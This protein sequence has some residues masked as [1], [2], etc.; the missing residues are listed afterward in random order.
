MTDPQASEAR[1]LHPAREHEHEPQRPQVVEVELTDN[2]YTLSV[3]DAQGNV[4]DAVSGLLPSGIPA[5]EFLRQQGVQVSEGS[6]EFAHLT[7]GDETVG[8]WRAQGTTTTGW[9]ATKERVGGRNAARAVPVA[10]EPP[11]GPSRGAEAD[12]GVRAG[13]SERTISVSEQSIDAAAA[14]SAD[15]LRSAAEHDG[16]IEQT[17]RAEVNFDH[18]MTTN[19]Y[20]G[21]DQTW[22]QNRPTTATAP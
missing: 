2:E 20:T 9:D 16:A 15:G 13:D 12:R 5:A 7:R 18:A 6:W 3:R 11:T 1:D 22:R 21:D 17:A 10:N 4:V 19:A 8:G 14:R